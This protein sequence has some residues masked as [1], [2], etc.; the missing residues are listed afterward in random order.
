MKRIERNT[1]NSLRKDITKD[2]INVEIPESWSHEGKQAIHEML[3][4][5]KGFRAA[6]INWN[7]ILNEYCIHYIP[8]PCS[9]ARMRQELE[10]IDFVVLYLNRSDYTWNGFHKPA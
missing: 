3:T 7:S 4:I 2:T 1:L 8:D 5:E 10:D 9:E 6:R